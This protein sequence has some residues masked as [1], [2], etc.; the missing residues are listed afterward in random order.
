MFVALKKVYALQRSAMWRVKHESSGP[1][2]IAAHYK[3][4]VAAGP[5]T[6]VKMPAKESAVDETQISE[7]DV[8]RIS[9]RCGYVL[10]GKGSRTG[11]EPDRLA[12]LS[13]YGGGVDAAVPENQYFKS[14]WQ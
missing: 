11:F 14:A 13:G 7:G 3:Q 8:D 5:G 10:C 12:A 4:G 1:A 2:L 9:S 6:H